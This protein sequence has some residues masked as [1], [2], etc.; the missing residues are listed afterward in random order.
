MAPKRKAKEAFGQQGQLSAFA[1][2]KIARQQVQPEPTSAPQTIT[3]SVDL[4]TEVASLPY[5]GERSRYISPDLTSGAVLRSAQLPPR[6]DAIR[7]ST[8]VPNA[9]TVLRDDDECLELSLQKGVAVVLVGEYDVCVLND[10]GCISVAGTFLIL[11]QG[12]RRVYAPTTHALPQ[13]RAER[14]DTTIRISSFHSRLRQLESLSP[15]FCNLWNSTA[16]TKRSFTLLRTTDDDLLRRSLNLLELDNETSIR[17]I[18]NKAASTRKWPSV[19]AIGSKSSGKSTLNRFIVNKMLSSIRGLSCMYLDLDP[20]QPEF[21]PA[22]LISLV[23]VKVP[24]LGPPFTHHASSGSAQ[25]RLIRSHAIAATSFKDDPEHYNSC[26]R[27]LLKRVRFERDFIVVNTCGWVNGLGASALVEIASHLPLSDLFVLDPVDEALVR[28][29]HLRSGGKPTIH[30]TPRRPPRPSS[31]TPAEMRAMQS[32]SYFHRRFPPPIP[33]NNDQTPLA[34]PKWSAKPISKVRPWV[35][36]YAGPSRGIHAVLSHAQTP[37]PAFLSEVLAGALVAIVVLEQPTNFL[38]SDSSHP[39]ASAAEEEEEEEEEGEAEDPI[40]LTPDSSSLPYVPPSAKTGIPRSL[41]PGTTHALGLA[42][43]RGI[44]TTHKQ[45]HLLTPLPEAE[46]TALKSQK[47]VLVRG[48]F[49]A[50]EWAYL[51]DGFARGATLAGGGVGA[52]V[53]AEER[54]WVSRRE[55]VGIE[56]KVWRLRHPPLAAA[57]GGR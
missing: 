48:A 56:G 6:P 26:V 22:G 42:L 55:R 44:D 11:A 5:N 24:I 39:T 2:A 21:G 9:N 4:A 17:T 51:E 15:F 57:M 10:T 7:L 46:M 40:S 49:D 29:I 31:R 41:N 53:A 13:L 8:F 19:M 30:H 25:Y 12:P 52:A 14:D 20:G 50:P 37:D 36:D 16:N 1:A 35:I 27:D 47:V 32:M 38:L 23:E 54:P 33:T 34:Q 3:D 18:L 43:V 28:E 45:L